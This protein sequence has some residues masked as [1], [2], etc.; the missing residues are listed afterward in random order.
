MVMRFSKWWMLAAPAAGLLALASCFAADLGPKNDPRP[1]ATRGLTVHEWGTF[2]T[3]SGSD[4]KNLKFYPYD[5]DL[6]DFVHGYLSRQSKA[7]P[8]GGADQPGDAR[9]VLL[10]GSAADRVGP[11]RFPEGDHDGMVSRN[12]AAGGRTTARWPGTGSRSC[13][14]NR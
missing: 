14:A 3:F 6:P 4:G 11:R 12:G 1:T 8:H 5:N 13:P 9:A 2:S 7:G 10:H